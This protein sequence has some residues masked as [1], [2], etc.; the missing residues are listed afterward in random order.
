MMLIAS[1]LRFH[2]A[3]GYL[4]Y[5]TM[6]TS[7]PLAFAAVAL[8]T[9]NSV[10]ALP[11]LIIDTSVPKLADPNYITVLLQKGSLGGLFIGGLAQHDVLNIV[12]EAGQGDLQVGPGGIEICLEQKFSLLV[13]VI[14]SRCIAF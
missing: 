3:P 8:S 9:A 5:F 4:L 2:P 1:L 6:L 10:Y 12:K 11:P 13:S 14:C 7:I